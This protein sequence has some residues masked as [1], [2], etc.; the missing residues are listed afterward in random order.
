MIEGFRKMAADCLR[1]YLEGLKKQGMSL[2]E[3]E[4]QEPT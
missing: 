1:C 2:S 4:H 3:S